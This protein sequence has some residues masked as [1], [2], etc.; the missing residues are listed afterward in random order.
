VSE[1]RFWLAELEVVGPLDALRVDCGSAGETKLELGLLSG[2]R[3][4][5]EVAL[6]VRSPL[7]SAGLSA[8]VEPR[9]EERPEMAGSARFL[10]WGDPQPEAA[11]ASFPPALLARPRPAVQESLGAAGFVEIGAALVLGALVL[12]LAERLR[13]AALVGL[14]AV[15]SA[16]LVL[17]ALRGAAREGTLSS[18]LEG[19]LSDGPPGR[20]LLVESASS[21]CDAAAAARLEVEPAGVPL[22]VELDPALRTTTFESRGARL[23]SLRIAAPPGRESPAPFG[24]LAAVWY[25]APSGE[26]L[27]LGAWPEER[28]EPPPPVPGPPPPAWLLGGLPQGRGFLLARRSGSDYLRVGGIQLVLPPGG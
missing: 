15:G 13:A 14:A 21:R 16:L 26:L 28:E 5:V 18:V 3:R 2:E 25:R 1:N 12:A 23:S 6:P 11:L 17:I 24:A 8:V 19:D 20:W 9:I 10:G 7:G 27:H 4:T 22:F